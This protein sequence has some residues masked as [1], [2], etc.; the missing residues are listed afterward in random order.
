MIRRQSTRITR[1][2]TSTSN[3][4]DGNSV[5]APAAVTSSILNTFPL[6]A[7]THSAL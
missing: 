5:T 4:G 2:A 1:S 7:L 6:S 3:L